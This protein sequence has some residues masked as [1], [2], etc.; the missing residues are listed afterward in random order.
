M[1]EFILGPNEE[2]GREKNYAEFF[3]A[4]VVSW[5]NATGVIV[6][7][8]GMDS[9]MTKPFKM[10]LMCR[11]LPVGARVVVMKQSGTYIVLG[12]VSLPN[13]RKKMD[14]LAAGADLATTVSKVNEIINWM[15]TQ[16]MCYQ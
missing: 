8:D 10:M 2:A 16:G 11:P 1:D 12:E 3:L 15:V 5:Q 7:L 6:K 9:A 14:N 4:T 13:S